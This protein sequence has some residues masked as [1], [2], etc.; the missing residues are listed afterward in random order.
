MLNQLPKYMYGGGGSLLS[1]FFFSHP[2]NIQNF[3]LDE[4]WR[5]GQWLISLAKSLI[6]NN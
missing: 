2:V 3:G 1:I 4:C 6:Y 5:E